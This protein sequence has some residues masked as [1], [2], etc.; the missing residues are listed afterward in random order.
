MRRSETNYTSF[1]S[2][3][4]KDSNELLFAIRGERCLLLGQPE[5]K[6]HV[7]KSCSFKQK[8]FEY[9]NDLYMY[10]LGKNMFLVLFD[11]LDVEIG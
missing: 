7:L 1:E 10:I 11:V 6:S 2:S 4:S 9:S 8:R 5:E 3:R